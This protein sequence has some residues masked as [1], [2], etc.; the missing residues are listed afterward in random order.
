M[1]YAAQDP[2]ISHEVRIFMDE[3]KLTEQAKRYLELM[4]RPRRK[5]VQKKTAGMM[6]GEKAV[7]L[8]LFDHR[9]GVTA[10]D[11]S[12]ALEIGSGGIANLLNA[13]EKKELIERSISPDD[14]RKIIV[15]LDQ[16]GIDEIAQRRAEVLAHTKEMLSQ[17]GEEDTAQLI[18]I[19]E[20]LSGIA[21]RMLEEKEGDNAC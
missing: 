8:Y 1:T 10:G 11:L 20:K 5:P 16:K 4:F 18:R 12:K 9:Q 2:I 21:D 15:T 14:R 6:R 19:L 13:L 17:L 7:L 3:K